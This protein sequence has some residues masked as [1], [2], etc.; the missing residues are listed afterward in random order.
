MA[1][2]CVRLLAQ[3]CSPLCLAACSVVSPQPLWELVKASGATVSAAVA[4]TAPT[5]AINTVYHLH[6]P[7]RSLCIE[8]NPD[9]QVPDILPALQTELKARMIDSR[10]FESRTATGLC[11][12]WLRYSAQTAL[13]IPPLG[14]DY[15]PYISGATLT[16]WNGTERILASSQYDPGGPFGVGKWASTRAKLAPVIAALITGDDKHFE[17]NLAN[18]D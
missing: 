13:D 15:R 2:R 11:K 14:S 3:A 7:V 9:A 18:K 10:V 8:F 4:T 6:E 17:S 5:S 12:F 1:P 16:L